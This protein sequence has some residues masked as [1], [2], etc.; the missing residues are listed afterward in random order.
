VLALAALLLVVALWPLAHRALVAAYD[1]N[2]WKLG[3]FAMYTTY[4]TW[5]VGLFR[6]AD[7]R[8]EAIDQNA[9]PFAARRAILDFR[10]R[11]SALGR[12]AKP[13]PM[14]RAVLAARPDL[15]AIVVVVE[16]LVLDPATG[17]IASSQ[18]VFPFT[19]DALDDA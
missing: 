1:V 4:R 13:A 9:L 6:G 12:F 18:E 7:G 3:G 14:A 15:D 5:Q 11:R 17:R 8:L 10:A 2:P 16:R 19:R